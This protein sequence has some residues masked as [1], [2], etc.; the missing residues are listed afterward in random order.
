MLVVQETLAAQALFCMKKLKALNFSS[1]AAYLM[2]SPDGCGW[3]KQQTLQAIGRYKT[4]LFISY[5]YPELLLVPTQEIDQ[6]WHYH[7]LHTRQ[8]RQDCEIIFG[9][10]VDHEPVS[11]I[12]GK[13]NHQKLE[14]AFVQTQTLLSRFQKYFDTEV[15]GEANQTKQIDYPLQFS[16]PMQPNLHLYRSACGR[17]TN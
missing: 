12:E 11:A 6:V 10:Y 7:I 5:L 13:V 4:F 3:T 8:Y 1:I 17:P 14:A 16:T 2:N 15:L 9:Y